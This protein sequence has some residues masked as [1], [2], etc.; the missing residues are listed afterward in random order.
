VYLSSTWHVPGWGP[1]VAVPAVA[2]SGWGACIMVI[3]SCADHFCIGQVC[4]G[5]V[6]IV[7]DL[8]Y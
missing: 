1:S 6:S 7:C 5:I 8:I 3:R 2:C 4:V